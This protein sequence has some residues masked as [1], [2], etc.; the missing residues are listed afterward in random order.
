MRRGLDWYKRDPIAFLD[1][2]Q[3]FGPELIGAYAVILDLI[4]ARGGETKR[5]DRHL[6]GV[7][8]CSIRKA[9][10]LT[11]ELIERDKIQFY[12]G[13]M[14]NSR[15]KREAKSRREVSEARAKQGR[16]GGVKS[17]QSR[18]NNNLDE[19][20]GS[21][22]NEAEKIREDKRRKEKNIEE[23]KN[24]T[25]S[26][27]GNDQPKTEKRATRL[28]PDWEPSQDEINFAFNEGLTHEQVKREADKFKDYWIG[29]SDQKGTRQN[30]QS[31]WRNW[32]RNGRDW[33]QASNARSGGPHEA[34]FAGFERSANKNDQGA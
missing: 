28:S 5:D 19:P 15:A 13:F 26:M 27:A 16:K 18:K 9:K 21:S 1:A 34:L 25:Y 29:V 23:K 6:S 31:T 10:S 17:G 33:R 32:I 7:M 20:K 14:T 30:W 2:V 3:G 12:D 11:D 8:G 22:K 24:P 4:Y